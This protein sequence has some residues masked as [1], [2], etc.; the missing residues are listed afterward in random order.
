M[1]MRSILQSGFEYTC[2]DYR[3]SHS[4][5]PGFTF[6]ASNLP[7]DF[8]IEHSRLRHLFWTSPILIISLSGYGFTLFYPAA[9][10]RPGWILLPLFLQFL[11]AFTAHA[12]CTIT[13]TLVVDLWHQ[14]DH[15]CLAANDLAQFSLAALGV[16]FVQLMLDGFGT[17]CAFVILGIVVMVLV[18]LP[19]VHWYWGVEWRAEREARME[20]IGRLTKV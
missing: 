5:P 18:P 20:I 17:W 10:E 3:I 13:Q 4:L 6:T 9:C 2:S 12:I 7:S 16:G 1:M 15:A 11:I 14:S 19:V 8:L